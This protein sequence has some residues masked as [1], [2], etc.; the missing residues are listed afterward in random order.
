MPCIHLF[1]KPSPALNSGERT[2]L[3]KARVSK[4][5]SYKKCVAAGAKCKPGHYPDY[6]A[7]YAHASYRC[8]VVK[9]LETVANLR[10]NGARCM[11][12]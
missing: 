4:H 12:K 10:T 5:D 1:A 3:L 9:P 2:E 8:P 6:E 11:C 7:K